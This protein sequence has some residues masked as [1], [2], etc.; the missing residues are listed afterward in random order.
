M[1]IATT[2]YL[3]HNYDMRKGELALKVGME[4][5]GQMLPA[6]K[7]NSSKRVYNPDNTFSYPHVKANLTW[8]KGEIY[9]QSLE[10]NATKKGTVS[11][12]KYSLDLLFKEQRESTFGAAYLTNTTNMHS[13]CWHAFL[14]G[15]CW[16][17]YQQQPMWLPPPQITQT[18]R[19]ACTT[20]AISAYEREYFFIHKFGILFTN[21]IHT[22]ILC[23]VLLA[24]YL[25]PVVLVPVFE[26]SYSTSTSLKELSSC[27]KLLN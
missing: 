13:T 11:S 25:V 27:Q 17:L 7:H 14:D 26:Q 6:A 10:L 4:R 22:S 1:Y 21:N 24:G 15:F 9:F 23:T 5:V 12:P 20:P 3:P 19:D 16:I 18:E 8:R 2:A